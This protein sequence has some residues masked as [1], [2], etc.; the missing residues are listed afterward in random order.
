M[1]RYV[2]LRHDFP[3]GHPR[4]SHWDLMFEWGQAL[5]TWSL[6]V[7]LTPGGEADAEQLP[8]HRL[9]YLDYEGPVSGDRGS[10]ARWDAGMYWLETSSDDTLTVVLTG[11]RLR[12]TLTLQKRG[13]SHFWRVS[14]SADPT[15][16]GA[17]AGG[18]S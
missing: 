7:E 12:G 14:F 15:I 6:P 18:A 4:S 5:R 2:I 8:E 9:A 10:V 13:G 17:S 1:P 3:P 16:G 11:Q